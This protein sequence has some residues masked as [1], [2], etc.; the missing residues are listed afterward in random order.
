MNAVR[1][2]KSPLIFFSSFL[3]NVIS[4]LCQTLC[5]HLPP[6]GPVEQ[7]RDVRIE[8]MPISPAVQSKFAEYCT[9]MMMR[10]E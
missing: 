10:Q 5:P 7:T 2:R 3:P 9:T 4:R 8:N 6:A 1:K